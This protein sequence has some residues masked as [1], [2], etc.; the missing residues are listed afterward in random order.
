MKKG[1]ALALSLALATGAFAA[2]APQSSAAGTRPVKKKT[3]STSNA[4]VSRRLDEMQQAIG[5]QQQQ[6][7]NSC[8]N[9]NRV[10]R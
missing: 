8:R 9:C 6:T 1:M 10:M 7:S 4:E 3:A 5:A 2:P